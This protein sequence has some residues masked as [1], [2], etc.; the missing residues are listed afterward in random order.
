MGVK[1]RIHYEG[2]GISK[3]RGVSTPMHTM[4]Y[5][6]NGMQLDNKVIIINSLRQSLLFLWEKI[7]F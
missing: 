3:G 1:D 2:S 5:N 4:N 7:V 6:R